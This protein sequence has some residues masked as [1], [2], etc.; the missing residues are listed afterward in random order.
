MRIRLAAAIMALLIIP[1]IGLAQQAGSFVGGI[2]LGITSALGEFRTD[3]LRAGTGVGF[4]AELRYTL[5]QNFSFGPFIK[6]QRFGSNIQSGSGNI[7]YNFP[8]YGGL[9]RLNM[10]NVGGGKFYL[11]GGGGLFKP[12]LHLWAPDYTANE[13]SETGTFF[14]GGIGLCSDP[15]AKTIYEL[16]IRYNTGNADLT[17]TDLSGVETTSNYKYDF[18]YVAIKLSF[19]SKGITSPPRY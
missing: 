19:N 12:T 15:Y 16:E 6:Y 2:E 5:I 7:S 11:L 17:L 1:G 9:A 4:G 14:A 10:F 13:S 3:T 18:I 8:Q